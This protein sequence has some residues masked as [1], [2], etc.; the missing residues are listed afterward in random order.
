MARSEGHD[1]RE[2]SEESESLIRI[3][4]APALWAIHFALSYAATAVYCAKWNHGGDGMLG[5]RIGFGVATACVLAAI[6]WLGWRSMR[7]WDADVGRGPRQVLEDL[8]EQEEPRHQFLGHAALL[9][10]IISFVGVVYS[11]L[12]VALIG[13]CR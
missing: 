1:P 7:Q 6:A 5:F 4:L 8:V 13:T 2:F 3:T 9:L 12:P 11:A 10:S